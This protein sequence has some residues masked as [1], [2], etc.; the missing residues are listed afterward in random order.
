MRLR[1]ITGTRWPAR[2]AD[3]CGTLIPASPDVKV[4]VDFDARPRKTWIPA[5]SPDAGVW[6]KEVSSTPTATPAPANG[7][8]APSQA[9]ANGSA[10]GFTPASALPAT[11]AGATA[12]P[13]KGPAA[14]EPPA[15]PK[16]LPPTPLA[17][18]GSNPSHVEEEAAPSPQAG[19]AWSSGGLTV[20]PGRF[21]SVRS[22]Y[23]D[24]ALPGETAEE[25]AV[26]VNAVIESD[27]RSK[28]ALLVKLHREFGI[29]GPDYVRTPSPA[30][31]A[32][33]L[34]GAPAGAPSSP[35]SATAA[36]SP[37][38]SASQD[39]GGR[40]A[41]ARPSG[42]GAGAG[43]LP[44]PSS[45]A[46]MVRQVELEMTDLSLRRKRHKSAALNRMLELRGRSSLRE[47]DASD[48]GALAALLRAMD[49]VNRWDLEE[50]A[51]AP[52]P[53]LDG[54]LVLPA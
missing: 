30:R 26:R 31:A 19:R 6:G 38:A 16:G 37:G 24:Y 15:A 35:P 3:D 17:L 33:A 44:S 45:V 7:G 52:A 47:C 27:L 18:L 8:S 53:R 14:P 34:A 4:V 54:R 10:S 21:E 32:G 22:G 12:A 11:A 13:P 50:K 25:L 28:L 36:S 42:R 48:R 46:E 40:G 20:N 41:P 9:P 43:P 49:D 1:T 2:C 51:G 39:G 23:A 29:P 5:H